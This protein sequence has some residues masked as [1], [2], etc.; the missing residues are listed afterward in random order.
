MDELVYATHRPEGSYITL[1]LLYP[2]GASI[3][4]RVSGGPHKFMVSDFGA[5][6]TEA[7]FM[8]ADRLYTRQASSV[9]QRTGTPF[10]HHAFFAIDVPR[11]RIAGAITTVANCSL[12]AVT[13]AAFK[14]AEKA[15]TDASDRLIQ[16]LETVFGQQRVVRDKKIVGAS[17][18]EWQFAASVNYQGQENIFEYAT[19]NPT[20]I[21]SVTMKMGDV[22]LLENAPRRIVVVHSKEEL[23]TYLNVLSRTAHVIDENLE[24][25]QIRKIARAA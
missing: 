6:Y 21:A 5:G 9:S 4:V 11:D 14:L 7:E 2:S 12:E 10:D 13:L 22:A 20:S 25:D 1:P 16:R 15:R 18:H 24:V 17:N 23:G 3:V 19:R 8:G